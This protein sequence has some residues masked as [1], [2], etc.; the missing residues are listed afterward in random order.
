MTDRH[1]YTFVLLLCWGDTLAVAKLLLLEVRVDV[2]AKIKKGRTALEEL[3]VR[4]SN[5]N[6]STSV[7]NLLILLAPKEY[8]DFALQMAATIWKPGAVKVLLDAGADPTAKNQAGR[9]ALE[10][11]GLKIPAYQYDRCD[12][13]TVMKLLASHT[14]GG[15]ELIARDM[16]EN[17]LDRI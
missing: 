9:T 10:E 2:A 11:A 3:A 5:S 1:L 16:H 12:R 8:V 17:S 4:F 13:V 15:E 6:D 14:P 7:M